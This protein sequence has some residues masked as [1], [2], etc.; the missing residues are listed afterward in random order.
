M[1]HWREVPM[2]KLDL[3]F[4]TLQNKAAWAEKVVEILRQC[5]FPEYPTW[6]EKLLAEYPKDEQPKGE[7]S[8]D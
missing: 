1:K 3:F 2:G 6:I 5:K 7:D 4:E 8:H